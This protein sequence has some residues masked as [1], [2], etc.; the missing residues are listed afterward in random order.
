[1]PGMP[2]VLA[3]IP[4]AGGQRLA[5][6][7]GIRGI[8][9]LLVMAFHFDRY[10]PVQNPPE[11]LIDRAVVGVARIGWMGVDLF[12]VLS[13][14]LIT[15]I[16]CDSAGAPH[17]FRNFY[18]RRCLR[19][20]PVYYLTLAVFL[21]ALPG[22]FPAHAGLQALQ[23]EGI[24]YWTYLINE[25]IA[26]TGWPDFGALGHFWSLAVEEQFY[27]VWPVLILL[28]TRRAT[29]RIC[30]ALIP[31]ALLLRAALWMRGEPDAAFVLTAARLDALAVGAFI[32]LIVRLEGLSRRAVSQARW[33]A[34]GSGLALVVTY[35]A[36]SGLSTDNSVAMTLGLTL[37]ATLFGS[38]LVLVLAA[39]GRGFFGRLLST[40]P[41]RFFGKY[42]YA[43][44][45]AHHPL[46]FFIPL[47]VSVWFGR[48]P[49]VQGSQLP[50]RLA[51]SCAALIAT[52][53]LAM[54]SWHLWE[55]HFNSLKDRFR[56]GSA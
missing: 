7:D 5:T 51:F 13:G 25:R 16:L 44:Y 37:L 39:A 31:L 2:D 21:I 35:S 48:L 45:V 27:L 47:S 28:A 20:L 10:G 24:W 26:R 14:F 32:A 4:G 42:S 54:A 36:T 9:V 11:I 15:G 1:M 52:I 46:L 34:I 55:K 49:L 40:P 18:A 29:L 12:Y 43:M 3:P 56:Y 8:A 41:L 50:A 19:I 30:L 53:V 17:Y 33:W 23:G 38:M 6:L 22:M